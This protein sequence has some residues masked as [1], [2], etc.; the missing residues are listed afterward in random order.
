MCACHLI[1]LRIICKRQDIRPETLFD[2]RVIL[3][4]MVVLGALMAGI[5][6]LYQLILIRYIILLGIAVILF[7]KRNLIIKLISG[8]RKK[9]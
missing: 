7:I 3:P 1:F 5:M 2:I 9:D 6:C 8:I 4:V